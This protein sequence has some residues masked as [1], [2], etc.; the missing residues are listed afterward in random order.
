MR[1]LFVL[2]AVFVSAA[3]PATAQQRIAM[4]Q[5]IQGTLDAGSLKLE[6][7]SSFDLYRYD[8][9]GNETIVILM[10]SA[11]FDTYLSLGQLEDGSFTQ[12]ASDDDGA[13][14]TNSRIEHTITAAGAYMI[15]ANSL[16]AGETG[17]YTLRLQ[18]VGSAS[19]SVGSSDAIKDLAIGRTITD[20]LS[21]SNE[22]L[23]DGSYAQR[24]RIRLNQG[25]QIR[26]TLQGDDFDA[27]LMLQDPSGDVVASD[28]DGAG[29]TDAR[30]EYTSATAG[31]HIVV[32]NSL[33]KEQEGEFALFVESLT[34][35][36][37][38]GSASAAAERRP[39]RIGQSVNGLFTSNSPTLD[40][41]SHYAEYSLTGVPNQTVDITLQSD[42]FDAYL[43]IGVL[44]NGAFESIETN[45]DGDD[46]TNSSITYTFP[47]SRTYIIRANTLSE[48]E[49]GTYTLG[50][51]PA[52]SADLPAVGGLPLISSTI[53]PTPQRIDGSL[54]KDRDG[55][56]YRDY[57][58]NL[59][60]GKTYEITMTSNV[61]DAYLELRDSAYNLLV[62]DDDSGGGTNAKITYRAPA[63]TTVVVRCRP[64]DES[65]EGVFLVMVD[66]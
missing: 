16:M 48:G 33:G 45:D 49:T 44:T 8:S 1:H 17:S 31:P 15:R 56:P 21:A 5:S 58:L 66:D 9:P 23:G 34:A 12:L 42:D 18:R 7:G 60:A 36:N 62:S 3:A 40:D 61:F 19:A 65:G 27:Y 47:D 41:N 29:G 11:D 55:I 59:T 63:S 37:A 10:E 20:R 22:V 6:D 14:D 54:P 39:I 35:G 52:T 38:S 43:W 24:Y 32:V 2:L 53:I 57:R 30:I 28:D 51:M 25:Q 13:G 64:Y 50:V 4:G 46:G 26:I